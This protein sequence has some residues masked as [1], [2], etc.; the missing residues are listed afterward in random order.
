M[1]NLTHTL[2]GIAL[3][4]AA[5]PRLGPYGV[6]IMTLA[7]NAPDVDI[8]TRLLST[9]LYLKHHRGITHG[10]VIAPLLAAVVALLF[11]AGHK[12]ARSKRPFQFGRAFLVA[13]FGIFVAHLALDLPTSYGTRVLLPFSN[14]WLA[15][16][17][18][19]IV[20][21]WLLV[22]L[23]AS[24]TLPWMFGL[25][26]AEIGARKGSGRG[27]AIFVIA[28]LLLWFGFRGTMHSRAIALLE[29]H[30]YTGR[31][32]ARIG[33]FASFTNPFRWQ[34][35]VETSETWEMID[36]PVLDE[37]DPTRM[38]TYYK[39]EASPAL[40]AARRSGTAQ[41]FLD[42]ARFPYTYV[43]QTENGHF[44]VMRDLRFEFGVNGRRGFVTTIRLDGN[45]RPL[46]E[47]FQFAPPPGVR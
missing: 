17:F 27:A 35:V 9:T 32:P 45:L 36:V 37:F 25:I 40:D 34:G 43:E 12:L 5:G 19:P 44:V 24:L 29:S 21:V 11:L 13:L 31:Q 8:V 23:A 3:A 28:F 4:R 16:D 30:T 39:P 1:D 7:A 20:D 2:T 46:E 42:F 41:V 14:R 10:F 33:A 15:A 6:A 47:K 18:V 22:M 26:N 38:R